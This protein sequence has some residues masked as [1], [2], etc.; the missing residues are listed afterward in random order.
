VKIITNEIIEYL[1]GY[2][3]LILI[4]S[5]IILVV[6]IALHGCDTECENG[7]M[8]CQENVV[9]I[10]DNNEWEPWIDCTAIDPDETG[11]WICCPEIEQGK[12]GCFP[13]EGGCK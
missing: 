1:A 8:R 5:S 12:F 10:C 7:E 2:F 9:E 4:F 11:S 6:F 3:A 13:P